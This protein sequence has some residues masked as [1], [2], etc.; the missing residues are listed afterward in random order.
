MDVIVCQH[1]LKALNILLNE[2]FFLLIN[3]VE[4]LGSL[5]P[6]ILLLS[7]EFFHQLSYFSLQPVFLTGNLEFETLLF[8]NLIF[9]ILFL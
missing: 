7:L 2:V 1:I 4:L 8:L 9:G 3:Y 5:L 6:P